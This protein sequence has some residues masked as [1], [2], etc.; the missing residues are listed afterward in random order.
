M[1]GPQ[2]KPRQVL[3]GAKANCANFSQSSPDI[4][5]INRF[6]G[7]QPSAFG[8]YILLYYISKFSYLGKSEI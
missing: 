2:L 8:A 6:L 4:H 7:D 5:P 1:P 3:W